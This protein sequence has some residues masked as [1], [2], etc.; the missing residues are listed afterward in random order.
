MAEARE[1]AGLTRGLVLQIQQG[2]DV[3]LDLQDKA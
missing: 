3:L 1:P 2:L